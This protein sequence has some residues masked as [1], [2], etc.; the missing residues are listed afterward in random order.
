MVLKIW[1]AIVV[2]LIL[3]NFF[4]KDDT[5]KSYFDKSGLSLYTDHKTGLQYIKAGM[6]GNLIPRLDENGKQIKR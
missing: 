3:I 1:I 2:I 4:M 6:F 5:D